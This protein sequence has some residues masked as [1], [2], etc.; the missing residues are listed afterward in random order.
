MKDKEKIIEIAIAV[1]FSIAVIVALVMSWFSM[2]DLATTTFAMPKWIAVVISLAFDIGAIFLL[3]ITVSAALKGENATMAKL[4]TLAFIGTS[5][6]INVVHADVSGYGTVGMIMFGAA[7]AIVFIAFEIYLR[8]I[9]KQELRTQGLIPD[10]MPKV[11][12]LA[13]VRHFPKA[14]K[15]SS[16]AL[17]TRIIKE[18]VILDVKNEGYEKREM[19]NVGP[20]KVEEAPKP[21]AK[22]I[23]APKPQPTI[24][25]TTEEP[26]VKVAEPIAPVEVKEEFKFGFQPTPSFTATSA[27]GL[28]FEAY[29]QDFT[30]PDQVA[31]WINER[32]T[33]PVTKVTV[34]Q[35]FSQ[36]RKLNK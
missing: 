11:G 15:L 29:S 14:F 18:D 2:T 31:G 30:D 7:P 16:R 12:L 20:A 35:Y 1:L 25:M 8:H 26:E 5:L 10:R 27:R 34:Q 4:A 23:T 36:A 21:K 17:E 19:I 9:L 28:A 22:K 13:W 33:K 24:A 32:V 6:Y 3:L